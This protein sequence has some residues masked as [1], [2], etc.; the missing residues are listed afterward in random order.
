MGTL[1]HPQQRPGEVGSEV[2]EASG[3]TLRVLEVALAVLGGLLVTPPLLVMAVIVVVPAAAILALLGAVV[4]VIALPT[5][6]VRRVRTHHREHGSPLF[7]HRF[8][9]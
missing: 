9:M 7:L 2:V 5:A 8:G 6:L 1:T 4:A 3:V